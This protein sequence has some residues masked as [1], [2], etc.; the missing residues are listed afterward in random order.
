MYPSPLPT[1][2]PDC[3]LDT[4]RTLAQRWCWAHNTGNCEALEDLYHEGV[5]TLWAG[6]WACVVARPR[7]I[8]IFRRVHR[9]YP[10]NFADGRQ[11][12]V[13]GDWAIVEWY[14][15]GIVHAASRPMAPNGKRYA[16]QSSVF[17]RVEGERIVKQ[18]GYFESVGWGQLLGAVSAPIGDIAM[19][20]ETEIDPAMR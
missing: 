17:L 20:P 3:R 9:A 11:I 14:G 4:P 7:L 10:E 16:L 6:R 8:D 13:S 1:V 15:G 5:E 2:L 12:R 18:I 19:P